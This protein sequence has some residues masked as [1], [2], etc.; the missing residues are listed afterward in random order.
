MSAARAS[1]GWHWVGEE[2]EG[3]RGQLAGSSR[4]VHMAARGLAQCLD[5]LSVDINTN[6]T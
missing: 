4:P 2:P 6:S 3:A 5:L 1:L